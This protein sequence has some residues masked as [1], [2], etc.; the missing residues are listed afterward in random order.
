M[1][2]DQATRLLN[3]S[4][5]LGENELVLTSFSGGEELSRL[6]SYDLELVSERESIGANEIVGKS[7]TLSIEL[8]DESRTFIN[9]FISRFTADYGSGDEPVYRAELVPWLWFLTQT[10]DCRIFQDKT[11]P[12]VIEKIF[13]DLG[14]TDY[15][16]NLKGKHEKW[17]Y[18]VQYRETDFNFVSRLIELEGI[19]YYFKHEDGKHTLVLADHAGAYYDLPEKEVRCPPSRSAGQAFE[20]HITNW[21]H[22]Y[23]FVSG[24]WAQTD[25]NFETPSTSLMTTTNSMVDVGSNGKFEVYDYPGE[26]PDKGRGDAYTKTRIEEE[27]VAHDEV[28]AAST[29]RTFRPGGKFKLVEHANSAEEGKAYVITSVQHQATE[30]GAYGA[31]GAAGRAEYTNTFTCIPDSVVFRPSRSTPKPLI[32]GIQTAVVVGPKG[33]EIYCDKYGRV[34]VQFHWDREGKKDENSSLWIRAA[35]NIA[36]KQWG[37]MAIPRIGQE[38]VVEFLEGDPDRPLI[39]G[40]VYNA[41]QMPHYELPKEQNKTYIK[42]NSTKG[43]QGFNE[44]MFDDTAGKERLYMHA[45]HDMDVVV[46]NDSRE[47]IWGDR[48]RIIGGPDNDRGNLTELLHGSKEL[49]IKKQ[50]LEC[51]EGSYALKVGGGSE[52]PGIY[53]VWI[54][55]QEKKKIG[56]DGKHLIVEGDCNN[57]VGGKLS[58]AVSGDHHET[59]ANY[60]L[61]AGMG[62]VYIKGGMNAVIEAGMQLTLKVGGSFVSIG[63]AGVDISGPMVNINSGGAAGSGSAPSPTAP[64]EAPEALPNEPD[65][66]WNSTT[67]HKSSP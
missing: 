36:G 25:Y 12:E 40:C 22:Q 45:E 27:E 55:K 63:P 44:L 24:K 62:D 18:C 48:H 39:T 14:Y 47:H 49:T 33:E 11:V 31:G 52:T 66:A 34:K 38:V 17:E 10:A 59:C 20:D 35:Q 1:A 26:Y 46:K 6:F 28:Q 37:F 9:G 54:E 2:L 67:G 32:S 51:I 58:V 56:P 50:Q 43:G 15:Q 29:C 23:R 64:E 30:P 5:P 65:E 42:T 21:E 16:L 53:D 4:T 57:E 41:E 61:E 8:A 60:A 19:Y 7:V 3:I 13:Q